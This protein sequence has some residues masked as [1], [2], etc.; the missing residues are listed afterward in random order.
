MVTSGFYNSVNHDRRYSSTQFG[1][2]FDGIVRDGV[3][4]SIG[5]H[6]NVTASGNGMMILVGTGRAW[7]DHTWTLN[8]A[9]LPLTVPQSEI[10]MNRIDAV[11]LETNSTF[12]V[13]L[14]NIK[15]VKG[16]PSSNPSRPVLTKTEQIHQYPLAYIQVNAGVTSIRQAN[17]TN[18]IGTSETPFVTGILDTVNIDDLIAQWKDQWDEYHTFWEAEWRNWYIA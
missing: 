11:V 1:S 5:D 9:L 3:F 15:I 17:I 8:D 4:M 6:L 2:I 14:N 10:L 12:P 16:S 18:M 7:F 13:R